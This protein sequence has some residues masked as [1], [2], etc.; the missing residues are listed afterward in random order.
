MQQNLIF[1]ILFFFALVDLLSVRCSA[2]GGNGS[3][4]KRT[5]LHDLY[6]KEGQSPW[7]DNLC[8]PV[9][10]LIPF[11]ARG[12]RGVTSNPAVIFYNHLSLCVLFYLLLYS[13]CFILT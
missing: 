10:D 2:S 6:E 5:T 3:I 13:G 8:R 12:V 1:G 11:I 7:Y 4:A 9:T